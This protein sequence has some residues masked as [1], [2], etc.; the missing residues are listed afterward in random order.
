MSRFKKQPAGVTLI[1]LTITIAMFSVVMLVAFDA[2][3]NVLKFNRETVQKQS[4]QD[5][6]EFLFFLMSKEIRMA[7][8]NY[9]NN[10]RTYFNSL[11]IGD[12]IGANDTYLVVDNGKE[13]RFENY[14][15]LCVR[16]FI[17]TDVAMGADRLRVVRHDP[18]INATKIAWVLPV[19][20]SVTDIKFEAQNKFDQ[21]PV[22]P[23][24]PPMVKYS[25]TLS[26]SIWNPSTLQV[27]NEVI[28]RNFEQF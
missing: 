14:E 24:Q 23:T 11:T 2:F 6:S 16:Y 25:L 18:N 17:E 5:H 8:I 22:G 7:K 9:T 4:V 27:F 10:C 26:S 19:D 20:I 28:A 1:E 21:R 15:G 13:L 12:N 3:L